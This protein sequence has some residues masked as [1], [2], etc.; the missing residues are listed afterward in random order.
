MPVIGTMHPAFGIAGSS[1]VFRAPNREEV[2]KRSRVFSTNLTMADAYADWIPLDLE[3]DFAAIA[4]PRPL[5]HLELLSPTPRARTLTYS[6]VL[7]PDPRWRD[8]IGMLAF[9]VCAKRRRRY[10]VSLRRP[11][12]PLPIDSAFQA[13]D[14]ERHHLVYVPLEDLRRPTR[15]IRKLDPATA[16]CSECDQHARLLRAVVWQ[17]FFSGSRVRSASQAGSMHQLYRLP[18]GDIRGDALDVFEKEIIDAATAYAFDPSSVPPGTLRKREVTDPHS[19]LR[20]TEFYGSH[21]FIKDFA[22]PVIRKV[23][24]GSPII[25]AVAGRAFMKLN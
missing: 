13:E 24:K 12:D 2:K 9:P 4:A 25:D 20:S 18:I 14:V 6:R 19:G 8:G 11:I 1:H 15:E 10:V 3:S 16:R 5:L 17:A 21:S 22:S 7:G 23:K